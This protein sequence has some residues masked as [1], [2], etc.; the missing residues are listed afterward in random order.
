MSTRKQWKD[1]VID[2]E[3]LELDLQNPRLPKHVR[4]Q[5][6]ITQIR[7]YLLD[8][9]DVLRIARNIANNGYHRSAIAIVCKENGRTTVL[10]GNRRLA[11]C[12]LLLKP[13]LATNARDKK[14][15]EELS[16][17]TNKQELKKVKITIAP[18]R[19]EAEKEIWDIHVSQLLKPW[20]VLQKLRMYR[21]LIDSGEYDI[22]SA[23]SE[24]GVVPTQFK[25][26]LEKLFFYEQILEQI[27]TEKDEEELL[28][29]GFNKIDRLILSTNGKK[30]LDYS[31]NNKGDIT[32]TDRSESDKKLK[33]LIP[34]ITD[35]QKVSAQVTQE[36]LVENVFSRI[37]TNFSTSKK[38]ATEEKK[39]E[40]LTQTT[41]RKTAREKNKIQALFGQDLVLKKGDINNIYMDVLDLYNFYFKNA[42]KL[43]KNFPALIRMSL[44]LLVESATPKPK[45][46]ADYVN[47]NFE[48][49]KERLTQDQKTTLANNSINGAKN[50]IQ[51][52]QSG[53]HNY[54]NSANFE[55]T[56][57]MSV[58]I[59][60][61]LK[62]T[63]SKNEK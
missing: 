37:D 61:M 43:S 31:T 22:N 24:Y 40:P 47:A 7:N 20:Q 39:A 19:K 48:N 30:L 18:S 53:A 14:E 27:R 17:I 63:H 34:Y 13:E 3:R 12:Q 44:R 59:G 1:D 9:E 54:A 16:K 55:Q 50:L 25:K 32:F 23:S 10:D 38:G 6:D 8:K 33:Q 57:A 56:I 60:A 51:L 5:N 15:L 21:N 42:N 2:V 62:I 36:W 52:L 41:Q 45:D 28:K 35:P 11:A 46:I 4:D 29:S 26:E 49:A 58:I